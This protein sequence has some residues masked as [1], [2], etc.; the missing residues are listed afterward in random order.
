MQFQIRQMLPRDLDAVL[1]VQAACYPPLMQEAADV[2]ASR[3]QAGEGFCFVA[4]DA[5]GSDGDMLGYLFCYPSALGKVT[6]LDA[7]FEPLHDGDTLYL[8]DLA[9]DPR[10]HGKGLARLL[11]SHACAAGRARGLAHSALVS[12]QGSAPFWQAQGYGDGRGRA[13]DLQGYPADA[14]YLVRSPL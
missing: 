14:R 9:V 10:A 13:P 7:P 1:R 11:V 3:M 12:V 4:C 8:H 2:V 6:L 5:A